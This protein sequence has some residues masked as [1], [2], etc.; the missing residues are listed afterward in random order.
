MGRRRLL[1]MLGFGALTIPGAGGQVPPRPDQQVI[2]Q[3]PVPVAPGSQSVVRARIVIVSG[4]NEGVFVYSGTPKA[5]NPPIYSMSN[6]STD[7]FGNATDLGI[8]AY[9]AG[10]QYARLFE[11]ILQFLAPSGFLPATL[12]P[13]SAGEFEITSGESASGDSQATLTLQSADTSVSGNPTV[14]IG[15]QNVQLRTGAALTIPLAG[16]GLNTLGNTWNAS[17]AT[18][19]NQ[20][21]TNLL[22]ALVNAGIVA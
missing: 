8:V 17:T 5:G 4:A 11:G 3:P 12:S 10:G 6:S 22:N 20:N 1:G 21:F 13:P 19:C 9:A 2:T 18:Q 7:P 15:G 16:F 14:L